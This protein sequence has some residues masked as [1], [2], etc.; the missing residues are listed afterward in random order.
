MARAS[1]A[2]RRW[3][4]DSSPMLPAA[5]VNQAHGGQSGGGGFAVGAAV[6]AEQAALGGE[7]HHR[8]VPDSYG[9]VPVNLLQLGHETDVLA[10]PGTGL[11]LDEDAAGVEMDEAR[12]Q[13]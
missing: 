1:R 2:R 5:Q 10:H 7:A 6:S 13:P 11:A 3:P 4:P 8:H 12:P 9:K